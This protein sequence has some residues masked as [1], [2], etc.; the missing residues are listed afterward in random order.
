MSEEIRLNKTVFNKTQYTKTID[1]TFN[2][3]GVTTIQED[4]DAQPNVE[5]FFSL[6]NELFYIIP[7]LGETNSHQFLIQQSSDYIN[8]DANQEIIEELQ[9]E[10]SQL[11]TEL[12]DS[13]RQIIELETG[14]SLEENGETTN[15]NA[16]L[17][18]GGTP[19]SGGSTSS[20]GSGGGS[21]GG[22]GY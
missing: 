18:T 16:S 19:V 6:Y 15:N 22:G 13:Q 10:I 21:G 11:R 4:L 12:L 7:E 8:F 5:E 20:G 2:E 14:T 1:T 9:K 17:I 3:L